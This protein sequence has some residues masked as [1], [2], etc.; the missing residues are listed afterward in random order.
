MRMRRL[1]CIGTLVALSACGGGSDSGSDGPAASAPLSKVQ[2]QKA[3]LTIGDFESDWKAV[4]V[5]DSDAAITITKGDPSCSAL[6]NGP[7]DKA[8][9]SVES[10]F[11]RA[12]QAS[13]DD[14]VE[15]YGSSAKATKEW[16]AHLKDISACHAFTLGGSGTP[17]VEVEV[18]PAEVTDLG[19]E[20]AAFQAT[21]TVQGV[22]MNLDLVTVRTGRNVVAITTLAFN[23]RPP[24][25]KL[26]QKVQ[27]MLDRLDALD[28]AS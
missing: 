24:R 8:P 21:G 6:A 20:A 2:A 18:T 11:S 1:V 13:M 17:S 26:E 3:L 23:D 15:S 14:T 19:D 10:S 16:R 7:G 25:D 12:D 28:D 27:T 22:T 5:D 4:P 9:T